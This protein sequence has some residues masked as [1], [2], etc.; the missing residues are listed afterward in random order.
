MCRAGGPRC[1]KHARA[2]YD[3]KMAKLRELTDQFQHSTADGKAELLPKLAKATRKAAVAQQQ[4]DTTTGGLADLARQMR[5]M[6]DAERAAAVPGDGSPLSRYRE[7]YAARMAQLQAH[8]VAA[9]RPPRESLGSI[10]APEPPQVVAWSPASD[11][12]PVT[13][14]NLETGRQHTFDAAPLLARMDRDDLVEL[15]Y[16]HYDLA[17][18]AESA[19]LIPPGTCDGATEV[20]WPDGSEYADEAATSWYWAPQPV[21]RDT[22]RQP[23]E[24]GTPGSREY[25]RRFNRVVADELGGEVV[26][27]GGGCEAVRIDMGR[28]YSMLVTN[29]DNAAPDGGGTLHMAVEDPNGW[30]VD[31]DSQPFDAGEPQ[32]P[33][34][35]ARIVTTQANLARRLHPSITGGT[36]G[37]HDRALR[38]METKRI[39]EGAN[40]PMGREAAWAYADKLVRDNGGDR[41]DTEDRE[42][43]WA[44]VVSKANPA[45]VVGLTER[46]Q[47]RR[48]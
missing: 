13:V 43:R 18:E 20:G 21:D 31:F 1:T 8:D 44:A 15:S 39:L 3:S 2:A 7:G 11:E 17:A 26:N 33:G 32:S 19:G 29:G 16:G 4:L 35:I 10:D 22:A 5:A 24:W 42:T 6:S 37:S 28:G 14:T 47:T 38:L 45:W 41:W 12:F 48:Q 36:G 25:A 27:T 40:P 23:P 30:G 34:E 46:D 9:G